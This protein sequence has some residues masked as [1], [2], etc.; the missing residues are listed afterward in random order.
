M[1]LRPSQHGP[2]NCAGTHQQREDEVRYEQG[3]QRQL[4]KPA[5]RAGIYETQLPSAASNSQPP[6]VSSGSCDEFGE[7]FERSLPG[8][9]YFQLTPPD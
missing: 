5:K 4:P 3:F 1:R 8:C 6:P 9:G 7:Y 2:F